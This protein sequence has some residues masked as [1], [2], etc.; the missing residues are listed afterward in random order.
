MPSI[1]D[2]PTPDPEPA[3][4]PAVSSD[5]AIRVGTSE[6]QES[7][8]LLNKSYSDGRI[9]SNELE[10]RSAQVAAAVTRAELR[11]ATAGLG[12]NSAANFLDSMRRQE[13]E[14]AQSQRA[15]ALD[16]STRA[17]TA[18]DVA[19]EVRNGFAQLAAH[20]TQLG[21]ATIEYEHFYIVSNSKLF[22]TKTWR[23]P[24]G[25]VLAAARSDSKI[26]KGNDRFAKAGRSLDDLWLLTPEGGLWRIYSSVN[27]PGEGRFV[28]IDA[29]S[30][31]N[32][33]YLPFGG[34]VSL[35][36]SNGEIKLHKPGDP[37]TETT[38]T[39]YLAWLAIRLKS[40]TYPNL[41]PD[42]RARIFK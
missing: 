20:A 22:G 23:S 14:E 34:Q 33:L 36:R 27:S 17:R 29:D 6:R 32:G 8:A 15:Q 28:T 24:R 37:P 26:G 38:L 5:D 41:P 25:F 39:D 35:D 42:T 7:L 10:Q 31:A 18:G 11:S 19:A 1:F 16:A 13:A 2:P 9:N 12:G 4:D 30:I 3:A 21:V 40:V